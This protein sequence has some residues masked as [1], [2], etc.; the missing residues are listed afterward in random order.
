[1]KKVIIM[2][3]AAGLITTSCKKDRVCSCKSVV[4]TTNGGTKIVTV[5]TDYDYTITKSTRRTAYNHCTHTKWTETNVTF[6]SVHDLN[7]SLK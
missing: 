2:A 7:C 3:F 1:M 6:T 5:V 4:D